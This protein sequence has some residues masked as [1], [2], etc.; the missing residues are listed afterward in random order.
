MPGVTGVGGI[1]HI[2]YDDLPNWGTP[3]LRD[4]AIDD[5]TAPNADARA[6]TPG[7]MEALGV[8]LVEGR[9]FTEADAGS[10]G[11]VIIVDDKLAAR[12]WPGR[13]ALGQHLGVDPGSSG[14][15]TI[16]M[17]VVGVVKHLRLRSLV[18]DLTEQ[19]F[20]PV[21]TVLRNPMA[22]VVTTTGDPAALAPV[23]RQTIASLDPN[24]P[25]YD[26]R[27]LDTYVEG[28]RATRRFVMQLALAFAL[29]ALL[30]ACVGIYG[31]MAY[32]A[33][34]RRHEFGVRLALGAS[35]ARLV[36]GMLGE[37]LILA[38]LGC[39]LGLLAAAVPTHLLRQ[40]LYGITPHDTVSFA[41]TV[42]LLGAACAIAC[43][44]PAR[45]ALSASPMEVLRTE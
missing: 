1:S 12:M 19:I 21:R 27:P 5:P 42:L 40:Q 10:H 33:T 16:N 32:A 15:P 44:I 45:L 26:V 2:P 39:G 20:F 36:G 41:A 3:Y 34:E 7:L 13:S 4:A 24:L 17:T 25:I 37:G 28:A 43:W 29:A 14:R 18:D 38:T 31:V 11:L 30:L 9:L 23:L 22:Y 6:V 8:H 35:R